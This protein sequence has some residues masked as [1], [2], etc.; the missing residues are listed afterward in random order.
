MIQFTRP[1]NENDEYPNFI[2]CKLYCF[3]TLVVTHY[4]KNTKR[5]FKRFENKVCRYMTFKD[6]RV[7]MSYDLHRTDCRGVHLASKPKTIHHNKPRAK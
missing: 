1:L 4:V 2:E 3:N 6:G 5:A 7:N